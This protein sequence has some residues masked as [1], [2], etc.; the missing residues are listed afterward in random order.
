MES[1][2]L[3]DFHNKTKV[4][5]TVPFLSFSVL[6]SYLYI[7]ANLLTYQRCWHIKI[8]LLSLLK[9]LNKSKLNDISGMLQFYLIFDPQDCY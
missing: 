7:P 9:I 6:L 4:L 8:N 5:F 2:E 3:M 1:P